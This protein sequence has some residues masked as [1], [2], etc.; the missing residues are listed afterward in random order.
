MAGGEIPNRQRQE[1]G[2]KLCRAEGNSGVLL[3][4]QFIVELGIIYFVTGLLS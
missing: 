3:P 4:L 1:A 2:R